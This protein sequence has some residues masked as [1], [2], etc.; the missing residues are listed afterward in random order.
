MLATYK[1]LMAM[2]RANL[3]AVV[4]CST[5]AVQGSQALT[6]EYAGITKRGIATAVATGRAMAGCRSPAEML[7][8]QNR[9]GREAVATFMQDRN[10]IAEMTSGIV[11][12]AVEPY[13]SAMLTVLCRKAA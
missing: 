4:Q 8:V 11:R 1:D 5:V 2:G 7:S 10:R 9:A 6:Q 12:G 13:K 3:Q